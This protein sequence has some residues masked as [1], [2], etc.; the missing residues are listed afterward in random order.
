MINLI[1]SC[2]V[3]ASQVVVLLAR[4]CIIVL[5]KLLAFSTSTPVLQEADA[6]PTFSN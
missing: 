4:A 6:E 3:L 2:A 5:D 1:E